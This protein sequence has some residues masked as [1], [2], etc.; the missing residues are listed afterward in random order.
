MKKTIR[1]IFISV[2]ALLILVS[3]IISIY[4]ACESSGQDANIYTIISG[5]ISGIATLIIGLLTLWL[6]NKIDKESSRKDALRDKEMKEQYE[7]QLK[8]TASPIMYFE[9]IELLNFSQ[10]GMLISNNE[11]VNRLLDKEI[12]KGE[13]IISAESGFSFE[14]V[15]KTPKPE[16]I[17]NIY[18]KSLDLYI[19]K[20]DSFGD[21]YKHR[22]VN[23][24]T[25]KSANLKYKDNGS[26]VCH[27]DL[28]YLEEDEDDVVRQFDAISGQKN[29]VVFMVE[30]I[31]SN[32]LGLSKSYKCGFYFNITDKKKLDY[33]FT[34]YKIKIKDNVMWAEEVKINREK[35]E[36]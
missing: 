6:T 33:D 29:M 19:K 32:S 23:Y 9:N 25:N 28:L 2:V 22:F 18:V 30:L 21:E 31:A 14:F 12:D 4:F 16:N 27:T 26:L 36:H 7:N 5:W 10:A 24:S 20:E 15:F 8:L 34:N 3:I 17:E 35:N 1:Y 13:E 11:H